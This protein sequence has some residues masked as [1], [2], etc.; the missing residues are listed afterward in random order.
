MKE[1]PSVF[2]VTCGMLNVVLV[3]IILLG[4]GSSTFN[5]SISNNP[6]NGQQLH[7]PDDDQ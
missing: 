1:Q 5:K 6:L 7:I 2:S 3:Q 4:K